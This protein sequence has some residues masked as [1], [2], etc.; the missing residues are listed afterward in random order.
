MVTPTSTAVNE[1]AACW[2][3]RADELTDWALAR[4][5]NR[6]DVWGAYLP[7]DQ[8]GKGPIEKS[9]TAPRKRA[10]G[11]V[12]LTRDV[13]LRHFTATAPEH[14][15]GTHSTSPGNTCLWGAVETDN[16]DDDDGQ[17]EANRRT[18]LAWHLR[19]TLL[20]FRPVLTEASDAPGHY[21]LRVLF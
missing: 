19:L 3:A 7:L 9:Y 4:L 20:G 1:H 11:K 13:L 17:A 12:L 18:V 8:R 2:H 16:H 10:R 5:V 14:V 6:N 21:H 15:V